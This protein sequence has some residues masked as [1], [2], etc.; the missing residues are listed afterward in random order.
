[1]ELYPIRCHNSGGPASIAAFPVG[2]GRHRRPAL[3][4]GHE[5]PDDG[6][7]RTPRIVSLLPA[8]TEA[9]VALGAA[10]QLVGVS[11]ECDL[12]EDGGHVAR[13]SRPRL[14]PVLPSAAI[15]RDVRALVGEA[16][17]I[18]AVDADA[19]KALKPDV[20]VTQT[21]CA[22]CAVTPQ[23]LE[24]ALAGWTGVAPAIVSL[25]P[26]TLDDAFAD[27][28]RIADAIGRSA[29]GAGL[30]ASLRAR[31]DAL[32]AGAMRRATKP[33]LAV[34]EWLAPLMGAG[35]WIPQLVRLAH[36]EPLFGSDGEHT[37]FVE[38][39]ALAASD[40]DA[41]AFAPCGFPVAQTMEELPAMLAQPSWR[42]LRAVRSGRVLVADGNRF[43][44]RPGPSLVE[45][46]AILIEAAGGEAA[47]GDG[48]IRLPAGAAA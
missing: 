4:Q 19:L 27:M 9:I 39:E 2:S 37:P 13:P 7:M 30:V 33:R 15:D 44:N 41:I 24:A 6:A 40:P 32:A 28:R 38:F 18:Y 43:F 35:N 10:S 5:V 11:H 8:A 20:I 23:D 21:Q 12:P 16:L 47:G 36:A 34:V 45:T 1:M 29:A 17:S 46:L 26:A 22:V 31:I 48:W 14:D 25:S 42:A 3:A